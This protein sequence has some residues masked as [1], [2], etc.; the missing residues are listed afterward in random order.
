MKK[1]EEKNICII[2]PPP[3][4]IGWP[5]LSLIYLYTYLS[6]KNLSTKIID[7]NILF[8]K[9]SSL[10]SKKW[11]KLDR[12]W[13][14]NLFIDLKQ[15]YPKIF[16]NLINTLRQYPYIGI[17]I[18]KRNWPFSLQ[19]A[20]YI[21]KNIP[22]TK[23]VFGGPYTIFLQQD[24]KLYPEYIWVIGEGELALENIVKGDNHTYHFF[25]EIKD[26]DSLPFPNF[27]P[28]SFRQYSARI[29][30]ISSR[31]CPYQCA[32]CTEKELYRNFRYHSPKYMVEA[33]A[34]LSKKHR[35]NT[36]VFCD[37]LINYNLKWLNEF[38]HLLVN[39]KI[40]V[41]WEAQIRV[42]KNFP[43]ELAKLMKISG[44]YNLFVGLESGSDRILYAM[45]KGFTTDTAREFLKTLKS[46]NLQFEISLIVGYPYEDEDD[47]KKTI[48]F[49]VK[50][51]DIITKIAQIN[52]FVDYKKS[53]PQE[54]YPTD[55]GI[56]RVEKLVK[57][58][59]QE[60]IRY[61]KAFINNLI[62]K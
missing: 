42:V 57:I 36:F 46:A 13:E 47:F 2:Y 4:W 26:L 23:I 5:P 22:L 6:S 60:K 53:F 38:C 28:L 24:N 20:R 48:S 61:T 49:I 51:K 21:K 12:I 62:Y 17:S 3:S 34:Y 39:K 10:P 27:S 35:M 1:Q 44:C 33:M 40:K 11:L 41:K 54:T 16:R 43:Q 59:E 32:F 29:P 25:R 19:L 9:L 31:G 55:L 56:K 52:P 7:L 58:L 50:N 8:Y 18:S 45:K 37:S 30:L 14:N 15:K